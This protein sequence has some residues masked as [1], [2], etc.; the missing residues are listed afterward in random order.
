M[1]LG[2]ENPELV[3]TLISSAGIIGLMIG[4]FAAKP[5]LDKFSLRSVIRLSLFL[6]TAAA[7]MTLFLKFYLIL[8]GR[9]LFG[10]FSGV[11]AVTSAMFLNTVVPVSKARLFG[12]ST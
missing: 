11:L 12:P 10:F 4:S 2:S 5:W 3:D 6:S 1:Q 7:G 8:I 9:F